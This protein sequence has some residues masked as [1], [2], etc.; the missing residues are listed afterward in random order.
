MIRALGPRFK[1]WPVHEIFSKTLS[2]HSTGNGYPILIRAGKGE[3]GEEEEWC[4]ISV[5]LLSVQ[6]GSLTAASPHGHWL[7]GQDSSV[8]KKPGFAIYR[9]QVRASLPGGAILVW[10]YSKPLNPSC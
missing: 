6:I 7:R 8:D 4:L 5:A 2:I 9:L 1:T 3:G 10:A